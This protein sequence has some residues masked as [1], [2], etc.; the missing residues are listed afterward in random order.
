MR[1]AARCRVHSEAM[2]VLNGHHM[3]LSVYSPNFRVNYGTMVK[4]V[5]VELWYDDHR[6]AVV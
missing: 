4:G 1:A 3:L 6:V 5:T 2:N